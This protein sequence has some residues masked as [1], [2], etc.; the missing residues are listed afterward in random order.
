MSGTC[1]RC[2]KLVPDP[3][4]NEVE[5]ADCRN[6]DR[7]VNVHPYK[8]EQ[9]AATRRWNVFGPAGVNVY[10]PGFATQK[11]AQ[12]YAQNCIKYDNE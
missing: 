2:Y 4:R 7:P 12:R 3:C 6:L 10:E 5:S 1:P 9:D 11:E 8:L